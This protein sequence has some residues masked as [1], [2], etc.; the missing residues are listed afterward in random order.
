[1]LHLNACNQIG[2]AQGHTEGNEVVTQALTRFQG[3]QTKMTLSEGYQP[4]LSD[5][6]GRISLENH[7]T[8]YVGSTH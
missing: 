2:P 1:M 4:S 7:E 5:T 3:V 6:F 8:S